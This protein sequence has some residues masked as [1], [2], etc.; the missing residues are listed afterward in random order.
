MLRGAEGCISATAGSAFVCGSG[1]SEVLVDSGRMPALGTSLGVGE[2]GIPSMA[3]R[4]CVDAKASAF[5]GASAGPCGALGTLM[6]VLSLPF[7][8]MASRGVE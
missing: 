5:G 7:R 2:S 8:A 4:G 1:V 3:G 6:G